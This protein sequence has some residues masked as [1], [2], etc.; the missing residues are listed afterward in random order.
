M[1][2]SILNL[3]DA[4]DKNIQKKIKGGHNPYDPNCLANCEAIYQV[5]KN[6]LINPRPGQCALDLA[7]CRNECAP[8]GGYVR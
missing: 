3:G 7:C 5:C 6:V 8:P 1:K 2:K 4:L